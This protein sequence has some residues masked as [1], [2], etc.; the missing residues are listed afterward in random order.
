MWPSL[1]D[2]FAHWAHQWENSWVRREANALTPEV[3]KRVEPPVWEGTGTARLYLYFNFSM[4]NH[5]W[6]PIAQEHRGGQISR[7]KLGLVGGHKPTARTISMV[8][9]EGTTFRGTKWTTGGGPVGLGQVLQGLNSALPCVEQKKQLLQAS[10]SSAAGLIQFIKCL[11]HRRPNVLPDAG[12]SGDNRPWLVPTHLLP[13]SCFLVSL[14]MWAG[15]F[16]AEVG[17]PCCVAHRRT[18]CSRSLSWDCGTVRS[19][20]AE[21]RTP[22]SGDLAPFDLQQLEP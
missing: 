12:Q 19:G 4:W 18:S 20:T 17:A 10:D 13:A 3:P 16:W 9:A 22:L 5:R 2:T 15:T 8:R 11:I 1:L 21:E 14:G 6:L 7:K